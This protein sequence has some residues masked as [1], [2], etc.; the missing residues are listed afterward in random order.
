MQLCDWS[1]TSALL[2]GGEGTEEG[3]KGALQDGVEPEEEHHDDI[4]PCW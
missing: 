3:G 2:Q 1:P 4:Q